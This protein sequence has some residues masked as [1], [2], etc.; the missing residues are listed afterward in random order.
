MKHAVKKY[1]KLIAFVLALALMVSMIPMG[2]AL[3]NDEAYPIVVDQSFSGTAGTLVDYDAAGYTTADLATYKTLGEAFNALGAKGGKIWIKGTYYPSGNSDVQNTDS[4]VAEQG[5]V[6][7][8]GFGDS[9]DGGFLHFNRASGTVGVDTGYARND[10]YISIA[11]KGDVKIENIKLN[12]YDYTCNFRPGGFYS[13]GYKLILGEGISTQGSYGLRLGG[14]G[15]TGAGKGYDYDTNID[16]Y[17]GKIH[18]ATPFLYQFGNGAPYKINTSANYNF[19]GGTVKELFATPTLNKT[20]KW[21]VVTNAETGEKTV[22]LD[23]GKFPNEYYY[24]Y[25]DVVYNIYEGAT[26]NG[27]YVG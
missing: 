17:S 16:V 10:N 2:I 6:T 15:S 18:V 24:N 11:T 7:I 27:L 19:Y 23:S 8:A 26:I 12:T 22:E 13:N 25:E 1:N 20:S 3:A 5:L 9:S 21:K 14:Y 4:V